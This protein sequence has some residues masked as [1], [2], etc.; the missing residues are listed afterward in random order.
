MIKKNN[1]HV[2]P[3]NKKWAVHGE[4]NTR[5]TVIKNTKNE[6]LKTARRIAMNQKSELIIHGKDGKIKDKDSFGNDPFPKRCNASS[7]NGISEFFY[8]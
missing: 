3:H 7:V 8:L 5:N 2:I 4:G 6:A 1:Q